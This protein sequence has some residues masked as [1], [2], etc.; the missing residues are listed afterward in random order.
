MDDARTFLGRDKVGRDDP[1]GFPFFE[2]ILE[3]RKQRLVARADQRLPREGLD[4]LGRLVPQHVQPILRQDQVLGTPLRVLAPHLDVGN[5]GPDGQRHVRDKRPGRRRPG[6]QVSAFGSS[7]R[8]THVRAGIVHFL[9]AK[10]HLMRGE[11]RPRARTVPLDLVAFVEQPLLVDLFDQPPDGFDVGVL[12]RD[13]R[14]LEIHPVADPLRKLVPELLV[15]QDAPATGGVVLFDAERLHLRPSFQAQFLFDLNL[16][17]QSVRIP[18]R[19]PLHTEA[20]HGLVAAED[21]LDRPGQDVMDAG[22]AV[23]RGRPFVEGERRA[24]FPLRNTPRKD[25]AR[26]PP[27]QDFVL[28]LRVSKL[29]NLLKALH[30]YRCRR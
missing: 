21:V 12:E 18:A 3:I 27:T 13:V 23:G 4:H 1:P 6:Q 7:Y 19:L 5:V 30:A 10:A 9:V 25:L 22:L 14:M 26:F 11:Y 17:G 28:N 16:H 29:L 8:K 20:L 15:A 2:A 24:V